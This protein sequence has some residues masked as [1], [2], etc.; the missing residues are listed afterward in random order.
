MIPGA[1]DFLWSDGFGRRIPSGGIAVADLADGG[2]AG[3]CDEAGLNADFLIG[4]QVCA[5]FCDIFRTA[6]LDGRR[7]SFFVG[8]VG[9]A[10]QI[11]VNMMRGNVKKRKF[12]MKF[13]GEMWKSP[14]KSG[15]GVENGGA[16]AEKRAKK[17]VVN[18]RW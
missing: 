7:C 15:V 11:G 6:L 10:N 16:V 14:R 17:T 1:R 4:A 9:H 18:G 13:C 5:G 8:R 3:K 12:I 2:S